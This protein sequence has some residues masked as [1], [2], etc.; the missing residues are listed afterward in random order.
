[1]IYRIALT[2]KGLFGLEAYMF[3]IFMIFKQLFILKRI[4]ICKDE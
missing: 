4:W 2:L 3:D 1:M